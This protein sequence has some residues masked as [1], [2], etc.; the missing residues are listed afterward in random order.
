MTSLEIA[1]LALGLA[2]DSALV[3]MAHGLAVREGRMRAAIEVAL[4]FGAVQAALACAGWW[5]GAPIAE[6]FERYDHRIA[7]AL[8]L[9]IGIHTIREGRD[10]FSAVSRLGLAK[11][12]G[13]A[14][15]TSLDAFAAGFGLRLVDVPILEP[16]LATFTI[17]VLGS[18]LAFAAA[19]RVPPRWRKGAHWIAGLT[20]IA[21]G[22][23]IVAAHSDHF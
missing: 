9:A 5:S 3:A 4:V 20:L 11:L 18:G 13:T 6:R 2:V 19:S 22:A 21:I 8:L 12:V 10:D 23:R 15:A 1:L 17:T 7:F 14:I 16:A